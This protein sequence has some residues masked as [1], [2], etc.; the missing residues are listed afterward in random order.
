[1]TGVSTIGSQPMNIINNPYG[2]DVQ[3]FVPLASLQQQQV[4][5]TTGHVYVSNPSTGV[6][7]MTSQLPSRLM[8]NSGMNH[9]AGLGQHVGFVQP[10]STLSTLIRVPATVVHS[11][12]QFMFVVFRADFSFFYFQLQY[13]QHMPSHHTSNNIF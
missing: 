9:N 11:K 2:N 6:P 3:T 1:M 12:F 7:V 10:H 5:P 4:V 8:Q 13:I